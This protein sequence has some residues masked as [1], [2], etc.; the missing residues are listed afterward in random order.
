MNKDKLKV[1]I[2]AGKHEFV[3]KNVDTTRDLIIDLRN[4]DITVP[5]TMV[6]DCRLHKDKEER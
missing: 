5:G 3:Y 6:T 1:R 4:F 2:K